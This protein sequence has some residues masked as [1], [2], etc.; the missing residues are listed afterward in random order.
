MLSEDIKIRFS[1]FEP[2]YDVKSALDILL[3]ELHL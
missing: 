2:S 1:G 3:S